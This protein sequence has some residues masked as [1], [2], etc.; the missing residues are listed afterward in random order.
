[1][2]VAMPKLDDVLQRILDFAPRYSVESSPA[3]RDRDASCRELRSLILGVL[4]EAPERASIDLDADIGGH[5]GSYGPVP[6]VRV[7]SP[8]LSPSATA[9]VYLAYLFAADGSR[10]YLSL[11]Q[12]S[13]EL[14]SGR[15]RPLN[16]A[17]RLRANGADAR[18]S[19]REL[20]ESPLGV[21]LAVEMDLAAARAPVKQYARRRIA[22]YEHANIVAIQYD[23]R[24]IP[25][26]DVL[27][28]DFGRMLTLL[29][30][31]YGDPLLGDEAATRPKTDAGEAGS[32]HAHDLDRVQGL[33]RNAAIRRAVELYAED[34]AIEHFTARGWTVDRVGHL[35]LGYDLECRNSA[36]QSLHVEVK[37]TQGRGEEVFLTRNEVFHLSAD[38]ACPSQHA[39]YVLSKIMVTGTGGIDRKSGKRTRLFPW[40]MDMSLLT[41]MVYS[42]RMPRESDS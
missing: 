18:S 19:I 11:Q 20:L 32:A 26:E 21:D 30:A 25:S 14:R 10:V 8:E 1:M 33:L 3:M 12:G 38:A 35:K 5:Q 7:F 39:L 9:G 17:A 37:G 34:R 15:M 28:E 16:G 27:L 6:W 2:V 4:S 29:L 42:Y 22:N 23:S 41:P 31:L 24:S 36:G 40:S 13:S